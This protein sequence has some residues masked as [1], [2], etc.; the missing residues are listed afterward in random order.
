[1]GASARLMGLL[2]TLA[3]NHESEQGELSIF[4]PG[5]A[6]LKIIRK[7][8]QK[9]AEDIARRGRNTSAIGRVRDDGPYFLL[10]G[11]SVLTGQRRV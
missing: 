2:R 3:D 4:L 1:M 6:E 7:D 10:Q 9:P 8:F 5:D 11:A